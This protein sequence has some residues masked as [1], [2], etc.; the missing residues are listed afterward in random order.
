VERRGEHDLPAGPLV[1]DALRDGLCEVTARVSIDA[2]RQVRAM[3]LERAHGEDDDRALARQRVDG[4]ARELLEE[5]D[6]QKL[7]P[8]VAA[9]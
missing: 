6:A 4:G 3:R 7:D 2:H 9:R 5:V 1:H 8:F